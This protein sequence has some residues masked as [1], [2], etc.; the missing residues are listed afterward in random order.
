MSNRL[1]CIYNLIPR[2]SVG[3][4]DVG[5]DHGF[6]PVRL[7]ESGFRGNI[8]AS[9]LRTDPLNKAISFS[10]SRGVNSLIHFKLCD[11]LTDIDRDAIDTIVI[12]GMGG[13]TIT[14]I[15]D[16]DYWCASDKYK[17]ILQPMTQSNILRYWLINNGFRIVKEFIIKDEGKIYNVLN[18]SFGVPDKYSDAELYLGKYE[19]LKDD[20]L[21]PEYLDQLIRK[22]SIRVDG[23]EKS[24]TLASDT[25]L[26]K[27]ILRELIS[28]KERI[29]NNEGQ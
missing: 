17:L 19:D 24:S 9:D 15:L 20:I 10:K 4:V 25:E 26:N 28:Y 23:Q 2:D 12:A 14:H 13:E 5:T 8:I 21:F 1:D 29:K 16:E 3:V 18:V 11:G 7:A 22:F 6:I 27:S